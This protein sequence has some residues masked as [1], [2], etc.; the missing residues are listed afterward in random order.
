MSDI[1]TVLTDAIIANVMDKCVGEDRYT[2]AKAI[3]AAV[4]AASAP[5]QEPGEKVEEYMNRGRKNS[6]IV[7][8]VPATTSLRPGFNTLY[9]APVDAQDAVDAKRYRW[10]RHGDNDEEVLC[11]YDK[12]AP[13]GNYTMFLRRN[14][15]L[16]LA[17]DKAMQASQSPQD[18][19][20]GK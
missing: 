11:A 13:K 2:F 12:N 7:G 6:E 5:A 18:Q 17:I 14:E 19:V 4:L 10:L 16:D 1:K 20:K 15:K 9:T 8:T 3:E